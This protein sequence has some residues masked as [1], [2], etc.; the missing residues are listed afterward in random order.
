MKTLNFG[1]KEGKYFDLLRLG[2][3]RYGEQSIIRY[4]Y[5]YMIMYTG[6][7]QDLNFWWES[8]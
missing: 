7:I 4:V 2:A 3:E 1:D 6:F 8:W 5:V